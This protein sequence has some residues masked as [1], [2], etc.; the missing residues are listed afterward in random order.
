MDQFQGVG[1]KKRRQFVYNVFL[2]QINQLLN[3][4]DMQTKDLSDQSPLLET[5]SSV[6][7]NLQKLKAMNVDVDPDGQ[8]KKM[9]SQASERAE[10]K[11]RYNAI[12]EE[13]GSVLA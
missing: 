3:L 9:L 13:L 2:T 10:D 7:G 8:L 12:L 11:P 5:F 1:T 6:R 4:V